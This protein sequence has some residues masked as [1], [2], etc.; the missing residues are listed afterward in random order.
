MDYQSRDGDMTPLL[1]ILADVIERCRQDGT[2][3]LESIG[4]RLDPGDVMDRLAP[5]RR[6]M[7]SWQYFYTVTDPA[8]A[9]TLR[10]RTVWNPSQYDGDACI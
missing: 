9:V 3:V 8:L 5:Y 2:A 4:W 1:S 6:T 10:E 7:P